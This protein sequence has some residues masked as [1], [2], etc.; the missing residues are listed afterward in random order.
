MKTRR[1]ILAAITFVFAFTEAAE[2]VK[3]L[4]TATTMYREMGMRYWLEQAGAEM[5]ELA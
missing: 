5:K 3:H 1:W 4:T 2:A